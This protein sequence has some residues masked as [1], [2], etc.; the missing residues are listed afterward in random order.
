[1]LK[2]EKEVAIKKIKA[3]LEKS[4]AIF[5]TNVV[6]IQANE[7]VKVR[8]GVRDANGYLAV[9]RNTLFEQAAK[10][11]FAEKLLTNLK[12][13]TAVAFAFKDAPAVA[14]VIFEANKENEIITVKGGMLDGKLLSAAEVTVLAKLPSRDQMLGT[15]L[16]TFNAPISAFARVLFAISEKKQQETQQ[17]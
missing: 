7:S 6:G 8:K 5:L 10:G 14:K 11:T 15:L 3:N 16:A 4:Q 13:P 1:M 17:A 2:T 9:T 12:G